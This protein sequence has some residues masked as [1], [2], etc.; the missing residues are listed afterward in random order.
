M[1]RFRCSWV[2]LTALTAAL[3]LILAG[4]AAGDDVL[5][6]KGVRVFDGAQVIPSA[7][8][9]VRGGTISAVAAG[10]QI[11]AGA[12]VIDGHGKTL[13]PGLI[14]AHTHT[15]ASEQLRAAVVFGVTTELDMFTS[16]SFAAGQRA[17]QIAGKAAG[18]AD[19]L[20]AGT[21]VTAP[22]GHGTEYGVPIPT[23]TA[24]DQAD[25][26]VAAR[27]AEGSDYIK[28]VYDDGSEIGL[29]WKSIDQP[30][31]AAVI[32]AAKARKK[33]AVVHILA[34]EFAR[35]AIAA[36]ADGL[37]HL[38]VDKP[39]DG[40]FVRLAAERKVFIIPT[41]T[42][43]D[44]TNRNNQGH[45]ALAD[46]PALAPY[47]TPDEVR[48][49][50]SSFPGKTAPADTLRIPLET[51][52]A[53]K[54]AGVRILAGTDCSNP[55]TAHGASLH[56][57][58]EL[59][60]AAGLTPAEA[61]AAATAE[62]AVA[63]GL[64]DRGRITPGLRADFVLVDGD[65]TADITATR[66]IA[67]VWKHG[68]RIDRDAY[69]G[70]VRE[71]AE[72]ITKLRNAPAPPGSEPGLISDFEGEKAATKTAFGAGWVVSTDALR[73]GKSKAE[74]AVVDGGVNGSAHAL[75]ITGTIDDASG[76][77]WAGV[78][79][80]PG[81]RQMSAANLSGK[82]GIS[83]WARGD[84]KPAYV[85]VFSQTRGYIPAIKTFVAG[86]D[87]KQFQ[88]DWKDFDGLDGAASLGIFWGGGV[89]PGPFE[90]QI[91]DVR[92]RPAKAK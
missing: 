17:E 22:G 36:G 9:V 44:S 45:A 71:R 55:G 37:V 47:L 38:F 83:F 35:E 39:V 58:L 25:A 68:Q 48:M 74:T 6:F 67:G 14:D 41:L 65:P 42:V 57:E 89:D 54:A 88:F 56:H 46:D 76:Q 20:S 62:T 24:P 61:L 64:S 12:T 70:L 43:L 51:V 15:F 10:A 90:L 3:E 2:V 1:T 34:R 49:L 29:P 19:L 7:T 73:G 75:K 11:P 4:P 16:Q 81:P 21:L 59:L 33:L 72:A 5:A 30:T 63:F 18:R 87:W 23:L 78:L 60:V 79:F 40:A 85:M 69:R 80:S 28:I 27:V 53:L 8:V 77:H 66:R 82:A 52:K 50:K 26:F 32:R 13:F 84:G 31:L 86:R 92:L 91:D